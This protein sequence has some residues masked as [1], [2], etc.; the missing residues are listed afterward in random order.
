MPSELVCCPC[1]HGSVVF[2]FCMQWWSMFALVPSHTCVLS[3]TADMSA[4]W[5]SRHVRCVTQQS[6][7][8]CDTADMSAMS[9]S[10]QVCCVRKQTCLKRDKCKH[11]PP[12]HAQC[13][14]NTTMNAGNSRQAPKAGRPARPNQKAIRRTTSSCGVREKGG[15]LHLSLYTYK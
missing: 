12:L 4:V 5:H 6:C 8:L 1:V 3:H 10:R 13:K 9:H 15:P 14:Y 7:L 2:A 11:G